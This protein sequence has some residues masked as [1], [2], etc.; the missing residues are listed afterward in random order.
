MPADS[1]SSTLVVDA[2]REAVF[3]VL[4][5]PAQHRAIVGTGWVREPL[6]VQLLSAPGQIFRM[7]M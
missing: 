3:A 5:D 7:S 1:V 4:A 2:P 6:D